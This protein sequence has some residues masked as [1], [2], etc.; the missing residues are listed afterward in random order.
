MNDAEAEKRWLHG[1]CVRGLAYGA[2]LAFS[3]DGPDNVARAERIL[4]RLEADGVI[5]R[6]KNPTL[7]H[8]PTRSLAFFGV[9]GASF[10]NDKTSPLYYGFGYGRGVL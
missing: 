5:E 4:R 10:Q 6:G 9:G 1:L 2:D 8:F 3:L 7:D